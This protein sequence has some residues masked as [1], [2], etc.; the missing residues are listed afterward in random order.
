M[1]TAL[2]TVKDVVAHMVAWEKAEVKAVRLTWR[3]KKW[4]EWFTGDYDNF[5]SKAV[6]FYKHYSPEA[7]MDEW[8]RWQARVQEEVENIGIENIQSRPDL[9]AWVF[10]GIDDDQMDGSESHYK[11]HYNQIKHVVTNT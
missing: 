11:H 2:W 10:E 7:L 6:E 5:N 8:A 1:A 3:D 9:F 4:P